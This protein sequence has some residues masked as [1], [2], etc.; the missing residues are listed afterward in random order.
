MTTV[1]IS[2]PESLK[3]FVDEAVKEGGYSTTSEYIRELVREAKKQKYQASLEAKLLEG[4][5]SGPA[6]EMTD[7]DWKDI[8]K[9]VKVRLAARKTNVK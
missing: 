6:T 2:L 8:R 4:I 5:A 1:N 7:K 9:E 3:D